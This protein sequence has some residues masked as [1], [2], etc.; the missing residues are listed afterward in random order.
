MSS[1]KGQ[2]RTSNVAADLSSFTHSLVRL[3]FLDD[4]YTMDMRTYHGSCPVT[5]G[6]KCCASRGRVSSLNPS[7]LYYNDSI[8]K[9]HVYVP[10]S[11]N[12]Q[13]LDITL[14]FPSY[15]Q[16][17]RLQCPAGWKQPDDTVFPQEDEGQR[18]GEAGVPTLE[19]PI[20]AFLA[21]LSDRKLI[22]YQ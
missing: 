10:G 6:K 14:W 19:M 8:V 3:N 21:P 13:L 1:S 5:K 18:Q 9:S 4:A 15:E 2:F 20:Q 17:L 22:E 7:L 11:L 16:A 12:M